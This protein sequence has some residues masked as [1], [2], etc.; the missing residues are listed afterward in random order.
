LEKKE[1]NKEKKTEQ[2]NSNSLLT[3]PLPP[4]TG[5]RRRA[6]GSQH[7]PGHRDRALEVEQIDHVVGGSLGGLGGLGLL[8][9]V[10]LEVLERRDELLVAAALCGCPADFVLRRLV[11]VGLAIAGVVGAAGLVDWVDARAVLLVGPA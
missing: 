5:R 8:L 3:L 11:L 7:R 1:D 6:G 2:K 10:F 4:S 9:F